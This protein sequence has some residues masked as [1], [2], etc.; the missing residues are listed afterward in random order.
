MIEMHH[1]QKGSSWF[2]LPKIEKPRRLIKS[3]HTSFA[4]LVRW[5]ISH[6]N[7]HRS[8]WVG[9]K[10]QTRLDLWLRSK[11]Q[12]TDKVTRDILNMQSQDDVPKVFKPQ[13]TAKY[14]Y[15]P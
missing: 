15:F 12:D 2:S 10:M 9:T 8:K 1:V 11:N 4:S 5:D 14:H 13:I 7:C 6:Y 3:G